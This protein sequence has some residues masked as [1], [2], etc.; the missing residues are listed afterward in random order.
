MGSEMHE[1][2]AVQVWADI[3]VEIVDMVERLNQ[4]SGV[5]TRD[6]CQGTIGEGGPHPYPAHVTC[7]WSEEALPLLQKEFDVVPFPSGNGTWGTVL[8]KGD[9]HQWTYP[10]ENEDEQ[11]RELFEG[12]IAEISANKTPDAEDEY[13]KGWNEASDKAIRFINSLS[14]DSLARDEATSNG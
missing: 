7:V 5:R 8:R 6:S 9:G 1:T 3:D 4:I 14:Q 12:C 2:R 11:L 13:S 10:P